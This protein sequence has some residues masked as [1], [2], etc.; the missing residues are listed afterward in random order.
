MSQQPLQLLAPGQGQWRIPRNE[1]DRGFDHY[2]SISGG[3]GDATSDSPVPIWTKSDMQFEATK[4]LLITAN[5]LE[6]D[7]KVLEDYTKLFIYI[8]TS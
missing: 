6:R 5:N 1:V 7:A 3:G 2:Q 4:K 8:K